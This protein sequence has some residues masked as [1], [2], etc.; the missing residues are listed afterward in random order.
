MLIL[1]KGLEDLGIQPNVLGRLEAPKFLLTCDSRFAIPEPRFQADSRSVYLGQDERTSIL[2]LHSGQAVAISR[3]LPDAPAL[4]N[5]LGGAEGFG[6]VNGNNRAKPALNDVL[7]GVQNA[8]CV[9][10]AFPDPAEQ[11][12]MFPCQTTKDLVCDNFRRH[13]NSPLL[14]FAFAGAPCA[15]KYS[16]FCTTKNLTHF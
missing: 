1:P 4:A 16:P 11:V 7:Q 15:N 12:V 14:R 13:D 10:S 3:T 6:S 5:E 8:C 2:I 9:K